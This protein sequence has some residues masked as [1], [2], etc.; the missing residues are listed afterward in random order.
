MRLDDPMIRFASSHGDE[1]RDCELNSYA[2]GNS[3]GP[4]R[5]NVDLADGIVV[6]SCPPGES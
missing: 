1:E 4:R 2:S 5:C 6:A 3:F